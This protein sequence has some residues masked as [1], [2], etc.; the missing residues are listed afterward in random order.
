LADADGYFGGL[1]AVGSNT[2]TA[3]SETATRVLFGK[4]P[5]GA[6]SR[7]GDIFLTATGSDTNEAFST[8]GGGGAVSGNA[9][10]AYANAGEQSGRDAVSVEFA[11]WTANKSAVGAGGIQV[12][13]A[14]DTQFFAG[15]STL[16][17]SAIGGSAAV[18][19]TDIDVDAK[20]SFGNNVNFTAQ[21]IDVA[22]TNNVD[23]I[24]SPADSDFDASAE[25]GSGGAINGAA[26]TST[27]DV[28]NMG[29]HVTLGSSVKLDVYALSAH[30]TLG[31]ILRLEASGNYDIFDEAKMIAGG[32]FQGGG[33]VSD[34]TV[35]S[36][37]VVTLGSSVSLTNDVDEIQL[38]TYTQ[39]NA[40]AAANVN[41]YGA[42]GVAVGNATTDLTTN[43]TLAIGNN[44]VINTLESLNLYA[45]RSADAITLNAL[46]AYATSDVYNGTAIP[47]TSSPSA[48]ADTTVNS[49][50]TFGSGVDISTVR[51]I[52]LQ[53]EQG[54]VYAEGDGRARDSYDGIFSEETRTGSGQTH[55]AGTITF[56]GTA[57]IEAGYRYQQSVTIAS[58]GTVTKGTDT[59]AT[60][61]N[62]ASFTT[63]AELQEYVDA[64]YAEKA[65]LEAASESDSDTGGA[66][67]D[68]GSAST[69]GT[70]SGSSSNSNAARIA[71]IEEEIAFLEPLVS[72]LSSTPNA[73]VFVGGI[74][75]AG[76]DVNIAADS[77]SVTSG[78]PT[79]TAHGDP[80]ITITNNS[81]KTLIVDDLTISDSEG[82]E[83]LISGGAA[84]SLPAAL[85]VVEDS[86]GTG[87]AITIVHNPTSTNADVFLQGEVSNL[88]GLVDIDVQQ[89]DL[90]QTGTVSAR[91]M[92]IDVVDG[93]YLL[94]STGYQSFGFAPTSLA[95]YANSARG[96]KP[97]SADDL[98]DWYINARYASDYSS[99]GSKDAFNTWWYGTD[100]ASQSGTT[101]TMNV[102]KNWGFADQNDCAKASTDC[103][104]FDFNG[105]VSGAGDRGG[106]Y[107]GFDKIEDYRSKMT[108]TTDYNSVKSAGYGAP[109]GDALNAQSIFIN[110]SYIDINGTIR[111]G[112][113]NSWSVQ[114]GSGFDS[115]IQQYIAAKGLQAGDT[116]TLTPGQQLSYTERVAY[117]DE[118]FPG[119]THTYYV[120]ETRY[121]D[122][123]V[124]VPNSG[125]NGI[126]LSYDVGTGKLTL[127]DVQANGDGYVALRGKIMSTGTEGKILVD[128]GLGTID[129][130]NNSTTDLVVGD[131]DA[132]T[133]S[134]GIIK[135]T[136]TNYS[137]RTEWY[138]HEAGS[139]IQKYVTGSTATTYTGGTQSTVGSL[140]DGKAT[141]NYTPKAG[142]LY[143]FTEQ[144]SVSRSWDAPDD[145][146]WAKYPNTVGSWTYTNQNDPWSTTSYG[147]TTCASAGLC[148]A[149]GSVD[150]YL[151]QK[152]GYGSKTG[153]TYSYT[154]S[155]STYY[156]SAFTAKTWTI[157]I[158]TAMTLTTTSYVKADNP[159]QMQFIGASAGSVDIVS[160]SDVTLTG[161]LNN[162]AGSTSIAAN[163]GSFTMNGSAVISSDSL[164][165]SAAGNLG[166]AAQALTLTADSVSATATAG[167]VNADL[168]SQSGG[169]IT[170]KFLAGGDLT[171]VSDSGLLP[172]GS[173]TQL[174]GDDISIAVSSGG[175]GDVDTNQVFNL[176]STGLVT[177]SATGDI[178]LSQATGDLTVNTITSDAGDVKITLGNGS[179][180][181]GIGQSGYSEEELAY[182]ATVWDSL[183][184]T[185]NDAGQEAVAGFESQV[186]TSYHQLW[187]L[188]QRLADSSDANFTVEAQYLDTFRQ[189]MKN[190][191]DAAGTP[192]ELADLSDAE[193]TAYVKAQYDKLTGYFDDTFGAGSW[194]FQ[195]EG[196]SY[197]GSFA[198]TL[199]SASALYA[200]LTSGAEW[201]QSSLDIV[202]N[203]AALEPTTA[204]Y[205]S[206]RDANISG[207]NVTV[208]ITGGSVGEDLADLNISILRAN[209]TLTDAEKTALLEAGPGDITLTDNGT[210][211][212]LA[213]K[214]QDPIKI[215]AD[216]EVTIT[217]G[218]E[219]YV[220]SDEA[221]MLKQLATSGDIRLSVGGDLTST[222]GTAT[223]ITGN[224]L[225][226]G[227]TQGNLGTGAAPIRLD[228]DGVLYSASASGDIWLDNRGGAITLGSIGAGGMFSLTSNGNIL[229]WAGNG[230]VFHILANGVA[231]SAKSGS[232][233]YDIGTASRALALKLT[234]GDA[235]FVGRNVYVNI[236]GAGDWSLGDSTATGTFSLVSDDGLTLGGDIAA[237]TF[238]AN[239]G[240]D[241]DADA[242]ASLT[243]TGATTLIAAN[244]DLANAMVSA[245]SFSGEATAGDLTLAGVTTTGGNLSL[246][247][248][249][250]IA[251]TGAV[252]SAGTVHADGQSVAM[253]ATASL[254]STGAT[255]LL[256]IDHVQLDDITATGALTVDAGSVAANNGS[257]LTVNGATAV[258]AD[259]DLAL[260]R[261]IARNGLTLSSTSGSIALGGT[262]A[263]TGALAATALA[264]E[265]GLQSGKTASASTTLT[266]NAQSVAMGSG[267]RFSA[268][269]ALALN[270]SGDQALA[271]LAGG[272]FAL[273][274]TGGDIAF[275]EN[276][277]ASGTVQVNATA[278]EVSLATGTTLA[279]SAGSV[280]VNAG[281]VAMGT[282][283]KLQAAT[284]LAVTTSGQQQLELLVAGS[285]TTLT[286]NTANADIVFGNTVTASGN[287]AVNTD[288][289]V[290]VEA[291]QTLNAGGLLGIDAATVSM[292]TSSALSGGGVTVTTSGAQ[293]LNAV[294]SSGGITL[295]SGSTL[296]LAGNLLADSNLDIDATGAVTLAS[297]RTVFAGA[298]LDLDAASFAMGT[299]GTISAGTVDI[300]TSGSQT[301]ERVD[302]ITSFVLASG[303]TLALNNNVS[304]QGTATLDAANLTLAAGRTLASTGAM[305]IDAGTVGTGAVSTIS[306]GGLDIATTG[307]QSL[308]LVTS[309]AGLRLDSGSTLA[310]NDNVTVTGSA[311]IDAAGSLTLAADTNLAA[312]GAMEIDAASLSAATSGRISAGGLDIA[313]SGNQV[314]DLVNST[315]GLVLASTSGDLVFNNDVTITGNSQL[316]ALAGTVTLAAGQVV[317]GSGTL[318]I[319]AQG[320]TMGADS[321]LD[322]SG[323]DV[324]TSAAMS[325]DR[326]VSA[327]GVTLAGD[328]TIVL[329]NDVT[330]QG[331]VDIDVQGALTLAAGQVVDS[332]AAIDVTAASFFMNTDAALDAGSSLAI[333]TSGQ[334]TLELLHSGSGM[335]LDS[336]GAGIALG[337]TVDS[338]TTLAVTVAGAVDLEAGQSVSAGS[339]A[340]LSAGSLVM[341]SMAVLNGTDIAITT[342][343]DQGLDL[344]NASGDLVLASASGDIVLNNDVDVTGNSQVTALA[345]TAALLPGHAFTGTGDVAI[346]AD[347]VAFA[348]DS[349]LLAA[350]LAI[351]TS[352]GQQ[353]G[354]V[355]TTANVTLAAGGDIAL[356]N[357]VQALGNLTVTDA[358]ALSLA[359]GRTLQAGDVSVTADSVAMGTGSALDASN[360]AITTAG[361][362]ALELVTSGGDLTLAS[363][364]GDLTLNDDV[365]VTGNSQLTALDGTVTLVAGQVLATAGNTTVD[366]GSMVMGSAAELATTDLAL[367]TS[368]AQQ[369]ELVNA[370]GDL[371][372]TS[373]GAG[374]TLNNDVDV[375]GSSQLGALSGTVELVAGKT[376]ATAGNTGIDADVVVMGAEAQLLA[377]D[378]AIDTGTSQQLDLVTVTGNLVLDA[379]SDIA[380]H[381]DVD[382][383]GSLTLAGAGDVTVA[384]SQ[385]IVAGG[386]IALDADSVTMAAASLLDGNNVAVT[387]EQGQAL[388]LINAAADLTLTSNS[389]GI[390]LNND[391][392]VG[393]NSGLSALAGAV[394]LAAAQDFITTGNTTVDADRFV[395]GANAQ[396][397]ITDLAIGTSGDQWLELVQA[398]GD[399]SLDAGA[400]IMLHNDVGIGG[401]AVLDTTGTLDIH[402]VQTVTVGGSATISAGNVA[403][404]SGSL[405]DASGIT[406][407]TVMEQELE[408]LNSVAGLT[409]A[410]GTGIT[411]NNDVF[412]SDFIDIDAVEAVTVTAGQGVTTSGA[413]T[414]DAA[415]VAM[416]TDA[417]FDSDSLQVTTSGQQTL[418]ILTA[419]NGMVLD[420]GAG[421]GFGNAVGAGGTLDVTAAGAVLLE[422][423]QLVTAGSVATVSAGSFGMGSGSELDADG[424][425]ITTAGDQD[426]ETLASTAGIALDS[427]AAI[428]FNAGSTADGAIT[429]TA[430][431]DV[432]LAAGESLT[433]QSTL[434]VQAADVTLLG[435][436]L[437]DIAGT[438]DIDAATFTMQSGSGATIGGSL[439]VATAGDQQLQALTVTGDVT[440]A[441]G[442]AIALQ[443]DVTVQGDLSATAAGNVDLAAGQSVAVAQDVSVDAASFTMGSASAL[444]ADGG[445]GVTTTGSQ[446]V[447][448]ITS[449]RDGD[450]A[451]VLDAGG[452]ISGRSDSSVHLTADGA[453]ARTYLAAT[454]GVGDPLVMDLP[455]L[456]AVTPQGDLNLVSNRSLHAALL[457]AGNGSGNIRLY[458]L[459]DLT[460]EELLGTPWLWVEGYLAAT[461]MTMPRGMLAARDGMSVDN[462]VLTT[463]GPLELRAPEMA[464]N[465][466]GSGNA[467]VN[468]DVT[469]FTAYPGTGAATLADEVTL[470]VT[471]TETVDFS[472]YLSNYGSVSVPQDLVLE[473]ALVPHA[474][475]M[476]NGQ[477]TMTLDNDNP[478]GLPVDAQMVTPYGDFTLQLTG[479]DLVTDAVVTRY[480]LPLTVTYLG[481]QQ[482]VDMSQF[483]RLSTEYQLLDS[484]REENLMPRN[485]AYRWFERVLNFIG[486]GWGVDRDE[487]SSEAEQ[488]DEQ[489]GKPADYVIKISLADI[490]GKAGNA[491]Q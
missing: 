72:Q 78:T 373:T 86:S 314:L 444:T 130:I 397:W 464:L 384:A 251:F 303:S 180:V 8:A 98:V 195:F 58:S 173:G 167:L 59:V 146:Y 424:I 246:L 29:A 65:A 381:N 225:N 194:P 122:P 400:G 208:N 191:L 153:Y 290:N 261:V 117:T 18:S 229:N 3:E 307:A 242:G 401:N 127:A 145:G 336:S 46:N 450:N 110:A 443:D 476:S 426:I 53:A 456:S 143:Y 386:D 124:T 286:G 6:G 403:M 138:V 452:S 134:T 132:G 28:S 309:T 200:S 263:V 484:Q 45:G 60:T 203:S 399:A 319:D 63:S 192:T 404:G 100:Y 150:N 48:D 232:T 387:T 262:T 302:A 436:A 475:T 170:A 330:A 14:H 252:V 129:V 260:E 57:A 441:A 353:L 266:V 460:V 462:V 420:S 305:D 465:I 148:N 371:V 383:L 280:A 38:G 5:V 300:A 358:V 36:N 152:V 149:S 446:L 43:N 326:L 343:G 210:T 85:S 34:V 267:S 125:D 432:T 322:A 325:L 318:A 96:W 360:I 335:T 10:E 121:V 227:T 331:L 233:Y 418:E 90:V 123:Q 268:T 61:Q 175:I 163:G 427:G 338:A 189:Q 264:G 176:S 283:S 308:N 37:N 15:A 278:G 166:S 188:E 467:G 291:G 488:Q 425:A 105:G 184:L 277:S 221:M 151:T 27:I 398:T 198:Y 21:A 328:G 220:E 69:G 482:G 364:G 320:V 289:H 144:A 412:G 107:W 42:A 372:L 236:D 30:E 254:Q 270:S 50:I 483:Y 489:L 99:Y 311:D 22:A 455:W 337:N 32:A 310:L 55:G 101:D 312:T 104:I 410:S 13:A 378:L 147:V 128:D 161:N 16:A 164:V 190:R 380:F 177:M 216:G 408:R 370:T 131:I 64:L 479:T 359:A 437:L 445:I 239:L 481:Q 35:V 136:D 12:L 75:A 334:Q 346:D 11:A 253:A 417:A 223:T 179:L 248:S 108:L 206:S 415:S 421:I 213:I 156:G 155:Y 235:T 103:A 119:Y 215:N 382:V 477:V 374:I 469:G 234:G 244:V 301:L 433:G 368:G 80:T 468:L 171:V 74:T 366:A 287:L 214:Q 26:A 428:R 51:N 245:Q 440:L 411:L 438:T 211:V 414:L 193:V 241:I 490:P 44:V 316:T 389:S 71:E 486:V 416:G 279:S 183:N 282:D 349:T 329:N 68:G 231:L 369:L 457:S 306:A 472:R 77:I 249:D 219:V 199:D 140:V 196:G 422:A 54:D 453:N 250:Q 73:A 435:G 339:S 258:T 485:L 474:L 218:T 434:S 49:S 39:G 323:I 95:D 31:N 405:L 142:Q 423:A 357:D 139:A 20:V 361:D 391:V 226:L 174:K 185:G 471:N 296:A 459:G 62:I 230:D 487:G 396:L 41:V 19:G 294:G 332:A 379:G 273:T 292:E 265:V 272:S 354:L 154:T 165:L 275:T 463:S 2:A 342:V 243:T 67:D 187:L 473:Y 256:A 97:V 376:F 217:A 4:D 395:M 247:A 81:S 285:G 93:I 388:E 315:N 205:V 237:V 182:L 114:V 347:S 402:T 33:A 157:S 141:V 169:N 458:T 363:S 365:T 341:G 126:S 52:W 257:L 7:S 181:N 352:D 350:N 25:A 89:G 470:T 442:G 160:N 106:D 197:N 377:A 87:S 23:Q 118:I 76:G 466:D 419:A 447:S 133:S 70:S 367:T 109:S 56:N 430:T 115:A 84:N 327:G 178:A 295:S 299:S 413:F 362:Q 222:S 172:M 207:N 313:T 351:T 238:S 135:I 47:L 406:I 454:T 224:N 348:A 91:Q 392:S 356:A 9:S 304:S 409:L 1:I 212:A 271:Q 431:D 92:N 321:T 355:T 390:D 429:I 394:E 439:G 94:N 297:G 293:Q 40:W 201:T 393:G 82:G 113:E 333:T 116:V 298:A 451:I 83:V 112:N 491:V 461:D 240:G 407:T 186:T 102:Y 255:T 288:G 24:R 137:N 449:H 88:G 204:D 478:M 269:N 17:I 281:S 276:A 385:T 345:G 340:T 66:A 375:A 228:L 448:A 274:S 324:A 159:I 317:D 158:P 162:S 259:D 168:S 111:A 284:T 480:N 344:V 120:Y 202:I 79:I 209:P